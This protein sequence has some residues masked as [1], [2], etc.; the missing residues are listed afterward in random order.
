VPP[1]RETQKYVRNVLASSGLPAGDKDES[2]SEPGE[3][4]ESSVSADEE[5]VET[6]PVDPE[7]QP[8]RRSLRKS[9]IYIYEMPEGGPFLTNVPRPDTD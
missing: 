3:D 6:A 4:E 7:S 5:K 2:E 8:E 9:N 1:F